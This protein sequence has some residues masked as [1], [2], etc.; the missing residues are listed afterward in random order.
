MCFEAVYTVEDEAEFL[1][2]MEDANSGDTIRLNVD[3]LR[4]TTTMNFSVPD[5]HL[6][7]VRDMTDIFCP[8]NG[9]A[10]RVK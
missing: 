1:Q 8:G 7:G 10:F 6:R 9:S 5:I 4:L 3:E 2:A